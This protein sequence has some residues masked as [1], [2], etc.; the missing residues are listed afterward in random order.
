MVYTLASGDEPAAIMELY[1]FATALGFVVVAAGKG[2]YNPLDKYA[3]PTVLEEKAKQ[4]NMNA[5]MLCEFV[6]GS[7]TAVEMVAV[8]NAT[9]L[10]PD[11]RG[12]HGAQSTVI[13]LT[14]VF[15]PKKDGGIFNHIGVVDYA[16]GFHPGVFIVFTTENSCIREGLVQRDMGEGPYYLLDNP[17]HLCSIE[18]PLSVAKAVFYGENPRDTP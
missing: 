15:Y 3:T 12:M 16:I 9:G 7:K 8:S 17:Y 18:V 14:R 10:I 2:K 11:V 1:P 6:D 5:R 13:E 4:R